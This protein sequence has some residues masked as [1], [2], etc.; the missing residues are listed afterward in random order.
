MFI[1]ISHFYFYNL[2]SIAFIR[3]VYYYVLHLIKLH[4][5]FEFTIAELIRIFSFNNISHVLQLK[6]NFFPFMQILF[7]QINHNGEFINFYKFTNQ[8][9]LL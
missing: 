4:F 2:L 9:S 1:K 7:S 5:S 8:S 3:I 6:L